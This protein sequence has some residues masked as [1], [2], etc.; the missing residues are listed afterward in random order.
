MNPFTSFRNVFN[1]IRRRRVAPRIPIATATVAELATV[2]P[3]MSED[4]RRYETA[5]EVRVA[6]PVENE[7]TPMREKT[8]YRMFIR[9]FRHVLERLSRNQSG[10]SSSHIDRLNHFSGLLHS[11]LGR[12]SLYVAFVRSGMYTDYGDADR[13]HYEDVEDILLP[14]VYNFVYRY[15]D[16]I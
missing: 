2:R 9:L 11:D 13:M 12:D 10:L 6:T 16:D 5:E 15:R 4:T 8:E 3:R 1:N 14:L 7:A